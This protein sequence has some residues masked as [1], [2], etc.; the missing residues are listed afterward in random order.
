MKLIAKKKKTINHFM[1]LSILIQYHFINSLPRCFQLSNTKGSI[2]FGSRLVSCDHLSINLPRYWYQVIFIHSPNFGFH[3]QLFR[4]STEASTG[5]IHISH[6]ETIDQDNLSV[7]SHFDTI[8]L[9]LLA[10][11]LV[12]QKD[13]GQWWID[14]SSYT[15]P[16]TQSA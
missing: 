10:S 2:A 6:I 12:C 3:F 16:N 14:D 5:T 7:E 4:Q 8:I 13:Y 1:A 9:R 11:N 15:I